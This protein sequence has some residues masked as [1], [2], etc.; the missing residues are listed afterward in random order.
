MFI[1][2]RRLMLFSDFSVEAVYTT[3]ML[4]TR[5]SFVEAVTV[6]LLAT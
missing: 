2:S 5:H 3:A 6:F 4:A 1:K